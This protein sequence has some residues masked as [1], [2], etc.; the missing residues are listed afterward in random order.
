[1]SLI[2]F[3]FTSFVL[4]MITFFA[5]GVS[6]ANQRFGPDE[7]PSF[8]KTLP[9]VEANAKPGTL[10]RAEKIETSTPNMDAW[11]IAYV[12]TD[13][14][15]RKWV[16]TGMVAAPQGNAPAEGRPVMAWAHGTTG[17]AQSCGPSQVLD[18]AVTLNQYFLPSGNSWTDYGFP[19]L[20]PLIDQGY[21]IVATDYQG[22]GGGGRHQYVVS[23]TQGRDVIDSIRAVTQ[24][25]EAQA[26]KRSVV[27]GW[28]Q[29]GGSTLGAASQA[30]YLNDKDAAVTGI[31]ILGFVAMA[32]AD[33]SA[34]LPKGQVSDATAEK[35]VTDFFSL[36]STDV[37]NFTHLAMNLWGTQAAFPDKLKLSD[38][39]TKEGAQALDGI[40]ERKCVHVAAD[41]IN[42]VYG[43]TYK[44]LLRP[45]IEN[46]QAWLSAMNE[47]GIAPV[48]PLAPVVIY[49]GTADTVVPPVMHLKYFE[50]V[51]K[52]GAEVSRVQLPGKITHFG[53]PGASQADYLQWV[54]DRFAGKP[55]PTSNGCGS[56]Q[57]S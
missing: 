23:A 49:W 30:D 17:T 6:H 16:T 25:K 9:N 38:L 3:R 19:A 7:I 2:R 50:Q 31:N 37:F 5:V 10:L 12:S 35:F 29:G 41:T 34:L 52:V 42:Y 27:Y 36:M 46:A 57:G 39:F 4:S 43:K 48:K 33:I 18:P 24:L 55:L 11:R 20:K 26:S 40:L 13:I 15:G 8:Y 44:S 51:C 45:K 1:M 22:L 21:V 56:K 54:E 53:T 32:P 28:S 47:G 14:S